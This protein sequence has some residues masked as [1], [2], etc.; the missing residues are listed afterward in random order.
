MAVKDLISLGV[1]PITDLA[2]AIRWGL[3]AGEAVVVILSTVT[4]T[5][6]YTPTVAATGSSTG[7][8][9]GEFDRSEFD[10]SEFLT[11][12]AATASGSAVSTVRATG[13]L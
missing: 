11:E 6:S 5:G 1:G 12:G 10:P 13:S 2:H 3:S 7:L 8:G 4:A 9:I